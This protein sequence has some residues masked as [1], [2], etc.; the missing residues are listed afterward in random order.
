M[1]GKAHR[2]GSVTEPGRW[3]ER[4]LV[5]PASGWIMLAML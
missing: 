3:Q 2:P 5:S 1:W 4:Y